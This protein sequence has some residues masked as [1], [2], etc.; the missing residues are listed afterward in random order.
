[1]NVGIVLNDGAEGC[2]V[3]RACECLQDLNNGAV[4]DRR[5][6]LHEQFAA[7]QNCYASFR[8]FIRLSLEANNA[9]VADLCRFILDLPAFVHTCRGNH[10]QANLFSGRK[11]DLK[12][13]TSLIEIFDILGE[14]CSFLDCNPLWEI[15]REYKIDGDAVVRYRQE[16]NDYVRKHITPQD[17]IPL[18]HAD[19]NSSRI[20]LKFDLHELTRVLD[21]VMKLKDAVAR[22]LGLEPSALRILDIRCG[23]IELTLLIP[24]LVADVLFNKETVLSPEQVKQFQD[25]SLMWIQYDVYMF[26]LQGDIVCLCVCVRV[27]VCVC[28]CVCVSG[29]GCVCVC[30][31]L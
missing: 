11:A 3:S 27:C 20:T 28:V 14:C 23:C 22:I 13:A 15:I 4:E 1:M 19:E 25:L 24:T 17:F 8:R 12:K 29:C 31:C 21:D 18:N 10:T 30:A 6:R 7:I 26:N 5:F 2:R 9:S 16:Q